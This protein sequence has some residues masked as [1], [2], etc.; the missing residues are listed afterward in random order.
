MSVFF[1]KWTHKPLSSIKLGDIIYSMCY[2]YRNMSTCGE[3]SDVLILK[4]KS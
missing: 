4:K 2:N 1:V 3:N